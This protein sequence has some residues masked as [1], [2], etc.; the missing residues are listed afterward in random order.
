MQCICLFTL[1]EAF[2]PT[3][4]A[5]NLKTEA[6]SLPKGITAARRHDRG[7]T[8]LGVLCLH[9]GASLLGLGVGGA[10]ALLIA[11]LPLRG[12]DEPDPG[13]LATP[14]GLGEEAP[15]ALLVGRAAPALLLMGCLRGQRDLGHDVVGGWFLMALLSGDECHLL[16]GRAVD[17]ALALVSTPVQ[18]GVS[19]LGLLLLDDMNCLGARVMIRAALALFFVVARAFVVVVEVD[20]VAEEEVPVLAADEVEDVQVGLPTLL[21]RM[22]ERALGLLVSALGRRGCHDAKIFFIMISMSSWMGNLRW[23][24]MT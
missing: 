9:G 19:S 4:P 23:K 14:H 16:H 20:V 21:G 17:L 3:L 24:I 22:A 18:R 13:L 1:P 5:M 12:L 15:R 2:R 7:P 6:L 10:L 11:T 8:A